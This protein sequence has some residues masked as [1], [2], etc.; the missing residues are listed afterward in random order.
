MEFEKWQSFGYPNSDA[1]IERDQAAASEKEVN[2]ALPRV[3]RCT[4]CGKYRQIDADSNKEIDAAFFICMEN[5]DQVKI[6][7]F[8]KKHSKI[9]VHKF[10]KKFKNIKIKSRCAVLGG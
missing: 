1:W 6:H 4:E 10:K 8:K 2:K 3:Y 5:Q 7:E 9:K